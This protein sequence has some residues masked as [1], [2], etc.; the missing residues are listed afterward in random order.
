MRSRGTGE[1]RVPQC[2]EQRGPQASEEGLARRSHTS[3]S[4]ATGAAC[5]RVRSAG[6]AAAAGH[7]PQCLA[8]KLALPRF[9]CCTFLT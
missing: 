3:V 1:T 4:S 9:L 8:G 2:G 6:Q 7:P 5:I